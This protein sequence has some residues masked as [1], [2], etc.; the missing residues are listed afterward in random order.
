MIVISDLLF[1]DSEGRFARFAT[2][3]Q[4]RRRSLSILQLD[5][6]WHETSR[7]R[8]AREFRLVRGPGD[9]DGELGAFDEA[10]FQ[11]GAAA[12]AA[13]LGMLRHRIARGGLD[14]PAEPVSWPLPPANT[15]QGAGIDALRTL[16]VGTFPRLPMLTGLSVGGRD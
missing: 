14:W 3:A 12:V 7:L 4:T 1:D 15:D 5:S 10:V 13:H 2:R 11:Q 16:F 8:A 6:L 9:E